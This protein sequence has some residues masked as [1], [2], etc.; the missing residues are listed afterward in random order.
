MG[1]RRGPG[2]HTYGRLPELM[3]IHG[4]KCFYCRRRVYLA[5]EVIRKYGAV[6]Q[7]SGRL[8]WS[9]GGREY[10]ELM[11]TA[12]HKVP[13]SRGGS[14]GLSNLVLAC[15]PCNSDK[16]EGERH[17]G[18]HLYTRGFRVVR[19]KDHRYQPTAVAWADPSWTQSK[20]WG[21]K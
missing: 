9:R 15:W 14:G 11:A 17:T 3:R 12:D 2:A 5:R 1:C 21:A 13:W 6:I 4:G 16:A 20:T 8:V 10:R 18:R 7:P 19:P